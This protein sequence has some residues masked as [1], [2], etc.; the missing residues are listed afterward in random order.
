MS[1]KKNIELIIASNLFEH[2]SPH[3][4]RRIEKCCEEVSYGKGNLIIRQGDEGDRLYIIKVGEVLVYTIQEDG[5]ELVFS[6]LAAGR[7][8]GEQAL[9]PHSDG[10]RNANVRALTD[11]VLLSLSKSEFVKLL[12]LNPILVQLHNKHGLKQHFNNL[13]AGNISLIEMLNSQSNLV[14]SEQP[15]QAIDQT[16]LKNI[17]KYVGFLSDEQINALKLIHVK[18]GD[19]LFHAGEL[20]DCVYYLVNGLIEI[21]LYNNATETMA[22]E[23]FQVYTDHLFGELGVLNNKPRLGTA[24]A[25]A[26]STLIV[27]PSEIFKDIYLQS[28]ILR[29]YTT[30]LFSQYQQN[31]RGKVAFFTSQSM[32][33]RFLGTVYQLDM[34][35]TYIA[36]KAVDEPL[37]LI[38]SY[39]HTMN[40]T[41]IIYENDQLY[42]KLDLLDNKIVRA[43]VCGDWQDLP[44]CIVAILDMQHIDPSVRED[45]LKTGHLS[46]LA[47][48]EFLQS[49]E[50]ESP[51]LCECMDISES[52]ITQLIK[53]EHLSDLQAVMLRCGAGALCGSC[54]PK[55]LSLLGLSKWY[56]ATLY[57]SRKFSEQIRVYQIRLNAR[58]ILPFIPGQH[59]ILQLHIGSKIIERSYSIISC[60]TTKDYYEIAIKIKKDGL[61]TESL[62]NHSTMPFELKV[63]KPQGQILFDPNQERPAICFVSGIGVTPAISFARNVVNCHSKRP[64]CIDYSFSTQEQMIFSA[65]LAKFNTLHNIKVTCREVK[66]Q[67]RLTAKNIRDIVQQYQHPQIYVCGAESYNL[68]LQSVLFELGVDEKDIFIERFYYK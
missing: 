52:Q 11:V 24:K 12:E 63:S 21:T 38:S 67:G 20:A 53:N 54:Q 31:R 55:I 58:A 3:H 46:F 61:F 30:Q 48:K 42:V 2:L 50:E 68:F 27:I 66:K 25:I 19:V 44:N 8:F 41:D 40:T 34:G 16:I 56:Y 59:I 23:I 32:K 39:P 17:H 45:F 1:A 43:E 5:S 60:P 65:E 9:L 26:P 6:H 29:A 7:Y 51:I 13:E 64:L 37:F 33:K 62:F 4:L 35:E 57:Y 36:Y 14:T 28:P 15:P 18:S 22:K 47:Q 49:V 10:R